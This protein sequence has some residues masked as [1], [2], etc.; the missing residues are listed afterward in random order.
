MGNSLELISKKTASRTP[1]AQ[2]LKSTV[3]KWNLMTLKSFFCKAK[4]IINR[5]KQQPTDWERI[6]TN[7]ISDRGL[8]TKI[9]KVPR[10][11][12][13]NNPNNPNKK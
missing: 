5:T 12:D 4:D 6:F 10:K 2:V 7:P 1:M 8:I 11:L 3:D 9:Y 13:T